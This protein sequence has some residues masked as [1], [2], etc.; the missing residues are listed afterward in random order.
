MSYVLWLEWQGFYAD[1]KAEG[2]EI[3]TRDSMV[4][5]ANSLAQRAGIQVGMSV[6]QARNIVPDVARRPWREEVYAA[7]QKSWLDL[8]LP[9]SGVIEPIDGHIAAIDLSGHPRP[10]EVAEKLMEVLV[11]DIGLPLRYGSGSS[12][13]V[14]SL[15]SRFHGL[16]QAIDDVQG[17]L[18]PLSVDELLP[19]DIATRERLAFL[20]YR[21]IGDVRRLSP[22]ILRGQ[23]GEEGYRILQ[24]ARGA[25]ADPVRALYPLDLVVSSLTFDG[26]PETV[27]VLEAGFTRMARELSE[28]L[29]ER[30]SIAKRVE[31][32]LI[33]EEGKPTV[34]RRTFTRSLATDRDLFCALRLMVPTPP[35]RPIERVTILLSDLRKARR[36]QLDVYEGRSRSDLDESVRT[37]MMHVQTVFGEESV[38]RCSEIPTPR[39]MRVRKAYRDAN[40]WP[41]PPLPKAYAQKHRA[42]ALK[43]A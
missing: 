26:S 1:E 14:A 23:F 22:S 35:E 38:R 41:W 43:S 18:E 16:D 34:L 10:R 42:A 28:R 27:E 20:G 24:A 13:W 25:V 4:L 12:K 21:K 40:G 29:T 11:D 2:P 5:D 3:V 37:A 17:F 7:A 9:F 33:H 30:N 6:S 39:W 36:V 31:L 19:V 8:C 15:A 32:T